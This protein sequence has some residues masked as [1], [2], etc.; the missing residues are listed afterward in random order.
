MSQKLLIDSMP[1]RV[2]FEESS[3]GV[4]KLVARGE[5]GRFNVPTSNNRLYPKS[6]WLKNRERLSEA[7]ERKRLFGELDHPGDGKTKLQRVSHVTTHFDVD[8]STGMVVAE[9]E[10]L[11]TPNGRILKA[12]SE[13]GCE[14]GV[15]SRGYGSVKTD[16]NGVEVVQD[17]YRLVGWDFVADPAMRTAYPEIFAEENRI[18]EGDMDLKTLKKDYPDLHKLVVEEAK[19]EAKEDA[20]KLVGE[21]KKNSEA[22]ITEAVESAR[23]STE[24]RMKEK[25]TNELLSEVEKAQKEAEENV[26]AELMTDP[27]VA[28]AK[29]AL[30]AVVE[31]LNPYLVPQDAAEVVKV[32]DEE[33]SR[34]KKELAA[35]DLDVQ[36]VKS[37]SSELA[38]VAKKAAYTL[39]MERMLR[40]EPEET[41]EAVSEL[42]GDVCQFESADEIESRVTA[43]KDELE[44]RA[45]SDWGDEQNEELEKQKSRVEELEKQNKELME[46]VGQV[47]D[48]A[49]QM[50][51]QTY[52]AN[53]LIGHPSAMDKALRKKLEGAKTEE[54][55]DSI[56]ESFEGGHED[57][58]MARVRARVKR[59]RERSLSEEE[60]GGGDGGDNHGH[61]HADPLAELGLSTEDVARMSGLDLINED[62]QPRQ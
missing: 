32:K 62:D 61:G 42:V 53:K 51:V 18:P 55:V 17:D 19:K 36:Q 10:F 25:F 45:S 50:A 11:D 39:H 31:T 16:E 7:I 2:S 12:L 9:D 41:F 57:E 43:I 21:V 1:F 28:G 54:E 8:D 6:V 35:K 37:E 44:R 52:A 29:T 14:L 38:K 34:L 3:D 23:K 26:R 27:G 56:V 48:L 15:S 47:G 4:K 24:E 33:I 5:H 13:A 60:H 49:K 40:G 22:A 58:E 59:G 46:K 20:E 30:E